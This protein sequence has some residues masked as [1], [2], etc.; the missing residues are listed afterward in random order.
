MAKITEAAKE[1]RRAY[2]RAWRAA[3][4]D[5]CREYSKRNMATYWEKK[6]REAAEAAAA[7]APSGK[8]PEELTTTD[9]KPEE[10]TEDQSTGTQTEQPTGSDDLTDDQLRELV[11]RKKTSA[12]FKGV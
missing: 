11:S 7:A 2:M 3:N 1:A 8:D 4:K 9:N 5:K 10:L 12:N 6:A